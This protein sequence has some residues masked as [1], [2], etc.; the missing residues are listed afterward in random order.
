MLDKD[1][2]KRPN[3]NQILDMIEDYQSEDDQIE[4][5][6]KINKFLTF[7]TNL[8]ERLQIIKIINSMTS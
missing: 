2:L 5:D 4:I 3:I 7:K 1:P 8:N 6:P